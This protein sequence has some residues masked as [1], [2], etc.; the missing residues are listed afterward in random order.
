MPSSWCKLALCFWCKIHLSCGGTVLHIGVCFVSAELCQG[1]HVQWPERT[2]WGQHPHRA[3]EG[4]WSQLW[5]SGRVEK[6]HSPLEGLGLVG[7]GWGGVLWG[8]ISGG[9]ECCRAATSWGEGEVGWRGRLTKGKCT[10]QNTH[11]LLSKWGPAK[12]PHGE[13]FVPL[14]EH[15]YTQ[16]K[17]RCIRSNV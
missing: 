4:G 10:H 3:E 9:G 17:Q 6:C 15:R 8:G 7:V 11:I 5:R 13:Q 14:Q 12:R 1:V 16:T 2:G